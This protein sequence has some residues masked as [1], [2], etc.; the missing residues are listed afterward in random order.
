MKRTNTT[1]FRC[2]LALALLLPALCSA[3]DGWQSL[4]NGEDLTGWKANY[5]PESIRVED[6][7]MRLRSLKDRVH[8]FYVGDGPADFVRFKNFELKLRARGEPNSNSGIFFHTDLSVRDRRMH[9]GKGYELNLNNSPTVKRKTGSLYAI[10]DITES[11]IADEA[12]WFDIHL[13]VIGKT[14]TI[15]LNGETVVE[16]TEPPNPERPPNRA[17]RLLDPH[18]G[19][20]AL[21]AHDPDSIFYLKDIRIKVLPD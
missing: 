18:G 11:P 5:Y 16:Y 14:I 2:A 12:E 21:Q 6:G 3:Q 7:A 19:A 17:G 15:K 4:F 20:I 1:V 10:K 8:L 13:I 9:L